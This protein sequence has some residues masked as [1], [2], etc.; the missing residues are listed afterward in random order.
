MSLPEKYRELGEAV[1]KYNSKKAFGYYY[2]IVSETDG[3][4]FEHEVWSKTPPPSEAEDV[5]VLRDDEGFK[6]L[7]ELLD[8]QIRED[9]E[10]YD[11]DVPYFVWERINQLKELLEK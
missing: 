3:K 10:E 9:I 8:K 11:R 7:L 4:E 5:T 2:T 6:E 1:K